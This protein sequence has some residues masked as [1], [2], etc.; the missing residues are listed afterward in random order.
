MGKGQ[1]QLTVV[2]YVVMIVAGIMVL[3]IANNATKA[4]PDKIRVDTVEVPAERVESTIYMMSGLEEG[5][6]QIEFKD[7]YE[8]VEKDGKVFLKYSAGSVKVPILGQT[9]K[10]RINPPVGFDYQTGLT[11]KLCVVKNSKKLSI[12]V[13]GCGFDS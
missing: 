10:H 3:A 11:D 8:V 4:V 7:D 12:N 13:E 1:N 6:T 9:A 5:K 2:I